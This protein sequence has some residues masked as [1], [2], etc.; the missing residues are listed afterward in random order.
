M[1][2]WAS[3][4]NSDIESGALGATARDAEV[5][6]DAFP[7]AAGGRKEAS[8]I[9]AGLIFVGKLRRE[10]Q[11]RLSNRSAAKQKPRTG[12][13]RSAIIGPMP[14][15]PIGIEQFVAADRLNS[16]RRAVTR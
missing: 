5:A 2:L 16:F 1:A 12:R 14:G 8:V 7:K 3:H 11:D 4:G 13:V 6:G 9:D 10:L 15:L